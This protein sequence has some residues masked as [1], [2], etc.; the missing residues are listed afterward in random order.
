[1]GFYGNGSIFGIQIY[2]FNNKDVSNVLF[3][4]KYA[5]I[6]LSTQYYN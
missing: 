1:M 6:H 3:E 4:E 2:N 5:S